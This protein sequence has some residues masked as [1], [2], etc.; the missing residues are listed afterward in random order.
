M[1][2]AARRVRLRVL[3]AGTAALL[4]GAGLVLAVSV[5]AGAPRAAANPSGQSPRVYVT[6]DGG[7]GGLVNILSLDGVKGGAASVGTVTGVPPGASVGPVAFN[8]TTADALIGTSTDSGSFQV[9]AIDVKSGAVSGPPVQ[10]NASPI[11]IA[12]DPVNAALAFVLLETGEVDQVQIGTTTPAPLVASLPGDNGNDGLPVTPHSIAVAPDGGTVYVGWGDRGGFGVD[13]IAV[14]SPNQV[15]EW[16]QSAQ[17]FPRITDLAVTPDG[18]HVVAV[19]TDGFTVSSAFALAAPNLPPPGTSSWATALQSAA[20]T[21]P[22]RNARALTIDPTGQDVIVGGTTGNQGTSVVMALSAAT[23]SFLTSG[24]VAMATNSDGVG[25]LS[26]LSVSPDGGTVLAAGIDSS[27]GAALAVPLARQG[28]K[29]I[30][31]ATTLSPTFSTESPQ[32]IA[33]TPDQA[34]SAAILAP[35]AVQVNHGVTFD[36]SPSTVAYGQV[37]SFSWSFGDGATTTTSSPTVTHSYGTSGAHTVTVTETDSAGTSVP[38][39]V[40]GT[41]FAVNGPG[42]T[43]YRRADPSA[44]TSVTI[45]VT[46]PPP[47]TST[48]ATTTGTTTTGNT[49]TTTTGS[50]GTSTTTTTVNGR[51]VAGAPTLLLNPAVGP[52][53]TIVTVTGTGFRPNTPVTVSWTVSTGS[54]VVTADRH[55]N[56]PPTPLP[57]LTPDV[58]GPR[59]AQASSTPPATAPFLVVPSTSEPGGDNGGLLFRSEGP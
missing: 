40:A 41:P 37:N 18:R 12:A 54:V 47:T 11:G 48:T 55:G 20:V 34:P 15:T 24:L 9:S 8:I 1:T 7:N 43:A 23:G 2:G 36:A 5:A 3:G 4:L 38:P 16:H 51:H 25:G 29:P 46:S 28:L 33:I 32:D 30:A 19:V 17:N 26:G 58:L 57:I 52:P 59:F 53:G 39:A 22:L 21:T 27:S 56:L 13:S 31:A 6:G 49:T 14:A 35:S 44:Q 50:H 10:L 42:Q 45:T